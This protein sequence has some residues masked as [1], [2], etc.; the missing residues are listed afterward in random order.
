MRKRNLT[1]LEDQLKS[2]RSF[3]SATV[4]GIGMALAEIKRRKLYAKKHKTFASY[5]NKKWNMSAA[6]ANNFITHYE[7]EIGSKLREDQR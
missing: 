1:D 6:M 4:L 7:K 2:A 3:Y 5:T